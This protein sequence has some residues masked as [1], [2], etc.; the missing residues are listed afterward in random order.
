MANKKENKN[1]AKNGGTFFFCDLIKYL[2]LFFFEKE[3][4]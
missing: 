2:N 4:T 1:I 3:N